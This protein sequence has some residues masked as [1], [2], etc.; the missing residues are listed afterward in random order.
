M[1][2]FKKLFGH[3]QTNHTGSDGP[4][5][6]KLGTVTAYSRS[7][8]ENK[9]YKIEMLQNSQTLPSPLE[10]KTK[11]HKTDV[12]YPLYNVILMV[13]SLAT[14]PTDSIHRFCE[15]HDITV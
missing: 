1:R 12:T 14:C 10:T 7:R 13:L 9:V 4:A 15:V 6:S 2:W 8:Y 3:G 11:L 5:V